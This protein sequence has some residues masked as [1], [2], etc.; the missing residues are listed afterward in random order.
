[1]VE[2][3]VMNIALL[4]AG[5]TGSRMKANMPKQYITVNGRTIIS[6]CLETFADSKDIEAIWIVAEEEWQ[7]LI[8]KEF[9]DNGSGISKLKG[10]S[11]PGKT[12]Q[13]SIVNG[14]EDIKKTF[15]TSGI[16]IIIH[17][18]ARPL[19]TTENIKEYFEALEGHDGVM[20]VLPMKDTIYLSEDGKGVSKLLD[21]NKLYAGQA[22]E[23]FVFNKYYEACRSLFP[24]RILTINGS[25]E[26]AI[27]GGLD[28]VMVPGNEKNFKITTMEDLDRFKQMI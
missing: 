22:P 14:L 13:L 10:F 3:D 27:Y 28:V 11:N 2:V 25:T 8:K 23:V 6:Y 4:L 18:A 19:L 5:G 21:R 20:P 12:R 1:M 9:V 16:N 7:E 26:P 15:D 17:D 24:D